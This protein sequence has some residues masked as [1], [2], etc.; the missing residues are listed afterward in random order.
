MKWPWQKTQF[1]AERK[2][3][4]V[5]SNLYSVQAQDF[6]ADWFSQI[7][8]VDEILLKAGKTR[9]ELRMLEGDDE[10]Y[11]AMDTR[12]SALL[13]VPWRIDPWDETAE[14]IYN[15]IEPF[16]DHALT[17]A[18]DALPYG[19]SVIEAVYEKRADGL[20]GYKELQQK[21][22]EWFEPRRDGPLVYY[23]HDQ[24]SVFRSRGLGEEV[25]Q[26]YKFFLTRHQGDYRQPYGVP[27]LSRLYW[28]WFFRS[29]GWQFYGRF[30]ERHGSPLMFG[31]TL[32]D[33]DGMADALARMVNSG[34][35]AFGAEDKVSSITAGNAGAAFD[36]FVSATDKRI[37]KVVLGQT[38]TTDLKGAGAYAA[39]QTLDGVRRDKLHSDIRMCS[40]TMQRIVQALI[41]LNK[42]AGRIPQDAKYAYVLDAGKGLS[43]DR[44]ERDAILKE[45]GIV[46]FTEKYVMDRYDFEEG[47]VVIPGPVAPALP[48]P[49]FSAGQMQFTAGRRRFTPEQ[50]DLETLIDN[51]LR[52]TQSPIPVDQFKAVIE[53]SSSAEDMLERLGALLEGLDNASQRELVE[54]ALF[55][56]DVMGYGASEQSARGT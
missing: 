10:I 7:L 21:P 28:P 36:A 42:M 40:P 6:F 27:M 20:I 56:A 8:D 18:W 44:A 4:A 38:G 29:N 22:F 31:N 9:A 5:P 3:A 11:A 35:A 2:T 41:G 37:Q 16:H 50:E 15:L 25:D 52:Q 12:R 43:K 51:T 19:Y 14:L 13:S 33:V 34:V 39:V 23:P 1:A 47:D 24:H 55:A 17:G 53:A 30:L 45:K 32:G 54:K 48:V 26:T 46:H 49:A